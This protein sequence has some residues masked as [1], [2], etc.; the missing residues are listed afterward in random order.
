MEITISLIIFCLFLWQKQP[1][2]G[3]YSKIDLMTADEEAICALI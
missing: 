2:R 1:Q 3:E